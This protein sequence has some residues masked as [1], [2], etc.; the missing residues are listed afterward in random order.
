MARNGSGV[1]SPPA[2]D[3]PAVASTLIESTKFNNVIDD[4]STAMSGS[5]AADG[6]TTVTAN[7]P[8]NSK[9]FTGLASGSARTD[10]V[11]LGQV[12]DGTANWVDGGGTA[13]AI[14]ATYSPVITTLVDGQICCVRATA[15]NATTTPTFAPNGLTARTIVKN[16]GSALVAGDIAAD[17]HEL[18][19]RYL[20]ASTRWELL[21]PATSVSAL[22][23]ASATTATTANRTDSGEVT[24]TA[25]ATTGDIFAAAANSILWD[26]AGGAIT[27]TAFP[28]A[29]KAGLVRNCRC[30]G[31]SKFTAGANFEI[32]GIPSGTTITLADKALFEVRAITTT[33]FRMT[34]SV[35]G[36]FTATYTGFTANPTRTACY[37]VRN[38]SV[39]LSINSGTVS[40]TSNTDD[41][42]ITGLPAA[43]VPISLKILPMVW[44]IDGGTLVTAAINVTSTIN[45]QKNAA[46]NTWTASGTKGIY[47]SEAV[48]SL[49]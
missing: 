48:Y 43:I 18:I 28:A 32:V 2:A 33:L 46:S 10:S 14:T 47:F 27:T 11:T 26:D 9:K 22:T 41:F 1:F 13:D 16:G 6:Q 44:G 12:Q 4:I 40:A 37:S 30:N 29:S 31:A 15:A 8:M 35:S 21:N 17:G 23:A 3:Y 7:I 5:V 24:V 25:H 45:V 20:L 36:T 49:Y 34:Y 38:G 19:L 39:T 42:T